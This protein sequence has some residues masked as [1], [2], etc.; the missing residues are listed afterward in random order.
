MSWKEFIMKNFKPYH[1]QVV[2]QIINELEDFFD[3]KLKEVSQK[4]QVLVDST[5]VLKEFVLRGGKRVSPLVVMIASRLVGHSDDQ[6]I[7]KVAAATEMHHLY[8]LNLDDMA[9]R[10]E[11]RHGGPSLE[12]FYRDELFS[13]W[14]DSDHHGRTFSS[15]HGALL[16]SYTFQLIGQ[17]R[18]DGQT[19]N[20]LLQIITENLFGDTIVGWQIQYFQ[21]HQPIAEARE[22]R[23]LKGLE[24]VTSRYKFIGPMKLGLRAVLSPT[25][26]EFKKM[27][28]I[29]TDYGKHVGIAFQIQDDIMGVFGDSAE[30]GKPVGHDLREGKKTLLVQYAYRQ[31][32]DEGKNLLESVVGVN[33][34]EEELSAKV[35][36]VR[37]LMVQTGSLNYSQGLANQH[38]VLAIKS[39]VDL[40]DSLEKQVLTELAEFVVNR[41]K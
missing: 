36:Q 2:K 26:P 4:D 1:Q 3:Q 8:L 27:E 35:E 17:A 31:A 33:L 15:I 13:S 10:D 39:L 14:P 22:D 21:N 12:A 23:F 28:K 7:W 29:L 24:Y 38:K 20:D 34:S 32:D 18:L 9:D 40:P 16:N 30:M 19:T 37:E 5:E 11:L 41:K 25:D 6:S